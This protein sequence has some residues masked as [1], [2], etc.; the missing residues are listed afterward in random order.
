MSIIVTHD[1]T[2]W[3][4]LDQISELLRTGQL[5]VPTNDGTLRLHVNDCDQ[6]AAREIVKR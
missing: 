4:S 2:E 5:E 3:L 1:W 6:V